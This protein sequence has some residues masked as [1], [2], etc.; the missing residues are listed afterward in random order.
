MDTQAQATCSTPVSASGNAPVEETEPVI[1]TTTTRR[2]L[3]SAQ[4]RTG[5]TDGFLPEPVRHQIEHKHIEH[6]EDWRPSKNFFNV[7]VYGTGS[8]EEVM[9]VLIEAQ[10]EVLALMDRFK[11]SKKT[12]DSTSTN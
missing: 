10:N 9:R 7:S 2:R 12:S 4:F 11:E 8:A 6:Q 3:T 1:I 5:N